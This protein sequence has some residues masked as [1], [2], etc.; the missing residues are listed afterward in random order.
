MAINFLDTSCKTDS[1]GVRLGI[2]DDTPND[3]AYIDEVTQ[4]L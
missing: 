3:P 2:C 4:W 1:S